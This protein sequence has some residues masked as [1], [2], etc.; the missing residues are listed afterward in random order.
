MSFRFVTG[1]EQGSIY[2]VTDQGDLLYYR[3]EARDGTVIWANGGI[4][5]RIGQGWGGYENVFSGGDGILYAVTGAGDLLYYRDEA[6]NGSAVWAFGGIGQKIGSGFASYARLFSGGDGIIYA[7]ALNGDLYFYRDEARDGTSR[8]SYGGVGRRIG[9][10]WADYRHVISGGDGIIYAVTLEGDLLFYRDEARDGTPL[11][12]FG[13]T[14]KQ[15]AQGWRFYPEIIYGGEGIIYAITPDGFVIFY[16]DLAR[17]GEGIWAHGGMG[18]QVGAGWYV[19]TQTTTVEG[20]CTPISVLPG[21]TVDFKISARSDYAVSYV[22]LKQ[23]DDGSP[24][25]RL[26]DPYSMDAGL[27]GT[28]S[29]AWDFGCGW[30]T[31]FQLLV[32]PEWRSGIYAARCTDPHG[33]D[34]YVVFIVKPVWEQRADIAVLA[35]T[36][37]WN[38]YNSWGGRCKYTPSGHA[39]VLSFERPNPLTTPID[40]GNVNHTTRAELW[41][42]NWLENEGYDFDVYS[43]YDFHLGMDDFARYKVLILTTHPEYWTFGMLDHVEEYLAAGGNLLYLGGN[44][45]FEQCEYVRD[46]DALRF[47]GGDPSLGRDRWYFR[48]LGRPEREIL[49]VAFLNNNYLTVSAPAPYKVEMS[50]HPFFAGT[51]LS[52]G[53]LIG[54]IGHNG[55][56]SGWEMDWS[57]PAIAGAGEVVSAWEGSDRGGRPATLQVLARG[58]NQPVDGALTAHMTYYTHDG[59]GFVF[60]AGSLCFGGS[61]ALDAKLAAIVKNALNHGLGAP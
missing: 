15:I 33:S 36:N 57:E 43:D 32:P 41:V 27:Q 48:N 38:A 35:N 47:E 58:T 14:G 39:P 20:Y 9:N 26:T 2:A 49:G 34:S 30:D 60:S 56:A 52:D 23:Q 10:G 5:Q 19:A 59:G 45:V 25:I 44:G 7:V 55:A 42:L 8:W 37:T 22:R 61:L 51:G 50:A 21:K 29:E 16:Q 4:G 53:D 28:P 11:W 31:S 6:R 12:A 54:Q 1:D 13:G 46:G 18:Q 40:D 17:N 3:D 24:G